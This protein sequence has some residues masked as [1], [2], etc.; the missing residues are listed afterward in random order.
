VTCHDGRTRAVG[1]FWLR[2]GD[3]LV[4]RLTKRS[5]VVTV[6]GAADPGERRC[7]AAADSALAAAAA[8]TDAPDLVRCAPARTCA[9]LV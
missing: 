7:R 1:L 6:L 2:R 8:A 3:S 5:V 9:A 4:A